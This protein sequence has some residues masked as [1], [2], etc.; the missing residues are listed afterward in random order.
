VT[1]PII[2]LYALFQ[3]HIIEGAIRSGIK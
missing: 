1:I 2:V 3:R